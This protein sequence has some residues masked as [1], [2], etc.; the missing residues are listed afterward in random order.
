LSRIQRDHVVDVVGR[1][2]E[3]LDAVKVAAVDL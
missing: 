1:L 3:P 2:L